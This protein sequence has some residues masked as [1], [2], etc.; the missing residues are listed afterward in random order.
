MSARRLRGGPADGAATPSKEAGPFLPQADLKVDG[1][2]YRYDL[3][4]GE[5][6]GEVVEEMVGGRPI[7]R[8]VSH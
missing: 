8:L 1:K 2:W 6:L 7:R 3:D 5:Y 4:T